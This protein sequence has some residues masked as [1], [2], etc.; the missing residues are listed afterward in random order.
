VGE[1]LSPGSS[2]FVEIERAFEGVVVP[3]FEELVNAKKADSEN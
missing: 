3:S 1:G 2:I